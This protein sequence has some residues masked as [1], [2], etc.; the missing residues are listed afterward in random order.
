VIIA[1]VLMRGFDK[2]AGRGPKQVSDGIR[3]ANIW[4][5]GF[6]FQHPEFKVPPYTTPVT[7][8]SSNADVLHH[9]IGNSW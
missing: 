1:V 8:Y 7:R 3:Q 2:V 4:Y 6:P 9:L 5:V